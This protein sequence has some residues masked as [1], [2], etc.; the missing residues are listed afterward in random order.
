MHTNTLTVLLVCKC[1]RDLQHCSV[2]QCVR[3]P[4]LFVS[5]FSS[6]CTHYFAKRFKENKRHILR[7]NA[8]FSKDTERQIRDMYGLI[9]ESCAYDWLLTGVLHCDWS[10]IVTKAGVGVLGHSEENVQWSIL[11][12]GV[13]FVLFFLPAAGIF[14]VGM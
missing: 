7:N 11:G 6:I 8:D 5:L 3:Q 13:F 10:G 2:Q 1:Y 14:K 12:A 4:T 9:P